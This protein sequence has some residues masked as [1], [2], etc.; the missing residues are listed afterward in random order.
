MKITQTLLLLLFVPLWIFSQPCNKKFTA[1]VSDFKSKTQFARFDIGWYDEW[2]THTNGEKV[3][4]DPLPLQNKW[5]NPYMKFGFTSAMHE[6]AHASDVSNLPGPVPENVDV[7]YFHVLQKGGDFSGMAPTYTF[8]DDSTMV[9]LSF[10][11]ANTT[12][13]LLDIKDTIKVLDHMP[14]PGRGNTALQ[15][16][17]K[18]GRSKIFSNTAGGA[19]SYLSGNDRIYIPG[20][21]NNILRVKITDRKLEKENIQS[22]N[23]KEQIEGGNLV[24]KS[25]SG[26]DALNLLTALMPDANGNLWFTSRQ[27]VVGLIH[28]QDETPEGCPKV[29]A[30]FIQKFGLKEKVR[31]LVGDTTADVQ[32]E[33][34]VNYNQLT[35]DIRARFRE[36]F[37]IDPKKREEIQNSFSVGNDGVY[38]VSNFALYKMWF[39]EK[40]KEIELDPQ[41]AETFHEGDLLYDND[42]AIKPG[43]LNAGSGT[44]PTLMGDDF[45]A[46]GDNDTSHINLC[47]YNQKTG[48]L[49]FKH[50]LFENL[51]GGAVENSIVAYQKSLVVANQYGYKDPFKLNNTA[52][53]IMRFDYNEDISTFELVKGWPE[54][55]LYD[56]KTATPKLSAP[57]GMIYVYN[58]SDEAWNGQYDWQ[59]TAIDFL[60]GLRVFYIKPFFL[61]GE[62]DDNIG[63]MLKWGSLGSKNYDRKVFNNIWG[64]FTFGPGNSFYIGAYRGF[65]R[66]SSE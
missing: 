42:G 24:D 10:G 26:K 60:T 25:I 32:S 29:Y 33:K 47:V 52:G 11:R 57:S 34:Y 38:I 39:N 9:T 51:E 50:R 65:I 35:T 61:K 40:K 27:G 13:L 56:C 64:T 14:V 49:V 53:G 12:L 66:I 46:I 30:T 18:K 44:T 37:M 55:G 54:S 58:R 36:E 5:E 21:N 31:R 22:V 41:W 28:R 23:L 48:K 63:P 17:G 16:A 7:Q 45:V 62:F 19:Y 6:D 15:L 4:P 3:L 1:P 8:I 59:V 2:L 43:M 20:A